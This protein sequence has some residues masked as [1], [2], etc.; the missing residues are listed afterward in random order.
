MIGRRVRE[1]DRLPIAAS[2]SQD[3]TTPFCVALRFAF[4]SSVHGVE[5]CTCRSGA[6]GGRLMG[7]G[8]SDRS[9]NTQS[10]L[11]LGPACHQRLVY[12]SIYMRTRTSPLE[13]VKPLQA[14]RSELSAS[15]DWNE[16]I[17]MMSHGSHLR[18]S[19]PPPVNTVRSSLVTHIPRPRRML[20]R[21]LAL[22][23]CCSCIALSLSSMY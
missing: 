16:I 18:I 21:C 6:A 12:R 2:L 10:R 8:P 4:D 5:A 15:E 20:V 19:S 9:E 14:T 17:M 22:Q 1:I 11:P 13:A 23:C 3:F 7:P